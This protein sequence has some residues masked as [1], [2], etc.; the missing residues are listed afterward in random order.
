M[1]SGSHAPNSCLLAAYATIIH[2]AVVA[3]VY[4][5]VKISSRFAN[6]LGV[7]VLQLS[8]IGP[9]YLKKKKKK[10]GLKNGVDIFLFLSVWIYLG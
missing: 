4:D 10:L 6:P 2:R 1:A 7:F 8:I 3:A 5:P 9:H